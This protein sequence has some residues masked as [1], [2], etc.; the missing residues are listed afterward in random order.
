MLVKGSVTCYYCGHVSGELIGES[1]EPM[2][3]ALFRP[4]HGGGLTRPAHRLRCSRCSGPVYLDDI[5]VIPPKVTV[6]SGLDKGKRR[7]A[8]PSR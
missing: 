3:N 7:Q 5:E 8:K 6:E 2:E 4:A 1:E